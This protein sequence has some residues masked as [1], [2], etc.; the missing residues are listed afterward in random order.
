MPSHRLPFVHDG[1]QAI[2]YFQ[3]A[4]L[5][6]AEAA[7]DIVHALV[8]ARREAQPQPQRATDAPHPNGRPTVR[9]AASELLRQRAVPMHAKAIARELRNGGQDPTDATVIS[10][11]ARLSK[12]G[13]TFQRTGPNVFGLIEWPSGGEL[14]TE[15]PAKLQLDGR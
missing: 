11:L 12:A 1:I 5:A 10:A 7:L 15:P 3:R 6:D 2:L 9:E 14:K 13:T 8:V 4:N